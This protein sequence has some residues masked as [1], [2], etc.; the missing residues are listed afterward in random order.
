ML[1][2]T[3]SIVDWRDLQERTR[4]LFTEMGY[5]AE[6]SKQAP[7]AGRG[8]KE[9]DVYVTDPNASYNR[10]YLVECKFW[11]SRVAQE[12]VHAFKTVM[13]ETGA[14]TGFIVSKAGFQRG[15]GEAARFTNINLLTFDELQHAYG[16]EWYRKQRAKLEDEVRRLRQFHTLHFDQWN[17][18]GFP[19]NM[20][21][22]TDAQRERLIRFQHW[23]TKILLNSSSRWP[24]S[25]QGPEPVK[26]ANNPADP[27]EGVS[28]WFEYPTVRAYFASI[29]DAAK[30]CA[31]EF[32][33]FTKEA[34]SGFDALPDEEQGAAHDLGLSLLREELPLR[35][36]KPHLEPE[37]F[38]RLLSIAGSP[39]R[40]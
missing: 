11:E 6:V 34:R 25:Y 30:R 9:I 33:A 40:R 22:R 23:I 7:L 27:D 12:T 16:N 2:P 39:A 26:A 35:V 5:I 4:Q 28:G 29:I 14:N 1:I 17:M 18:L 10:I 36:L 8:E 19:N 32:D 15:A 38:A 31:D 24:E 21:F 3:A 20:F 37:E 13:E